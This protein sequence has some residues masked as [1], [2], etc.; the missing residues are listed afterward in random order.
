[1][2]K[3][4]LLSSASPCISRIK[5]PFAT[6]PTTPC[7]Q[8]DTFG[9]APIQGDVPPPL[10]PYG[11]RGLLQALCKSCDDRAVA[12]GRPKSLLFW[13][14]HANAPPRPRPRSPL[15]PLNDF[16]KCLPRARATGQGRPS[17]AQERHC[18]KPSMR[19]VLFPAALECLFGPISIPSF[20]PT[21]RRSLLFRCVWREN[22]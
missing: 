9:A 20:G 8:T 2:A 1:M 19:K 18:R 14:S 6:A 4:A 21:E 15:V 3:T 10:P 22:E 11:V 5:L 17:P 13:K 7:V 12:N 16:R